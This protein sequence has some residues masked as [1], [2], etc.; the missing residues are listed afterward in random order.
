MFDSQMRSGHFV[1]CRTAK[2]FL[3]FVLIFDENQFEG[4]EEIGEIVENIVEMI[5]LK[6]FPL[7]DKRFNVRSS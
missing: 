3:L 6:V 1:K 5:V 7:T 2:V 4:H